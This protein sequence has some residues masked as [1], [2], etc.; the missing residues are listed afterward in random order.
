MD[1]P[2]KP[3]LPL[4]NKFATQE[5]FNTITQKVLSNYD[6]LE[7]ETEN[8]IIIAPDENKDA[9]IAIVGIDA[10]NKI[11]KI[12]KSLSASE[13]VGILLEIANPKKTKK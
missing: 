8:I 10:E 1:F 4:I 5:N 6:I 12:K 9:A 2:I 13:F 11:K 3:F 7:D